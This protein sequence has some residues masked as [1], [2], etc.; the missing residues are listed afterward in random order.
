[1]DKTAWTVEDH[2]DGQPPASVGLYEHFIELVAA[3]GPFSYAVSKTT[4]TLK[5]TRRGF[6]GG[7]PTPRG[8]VGYLDLQR[9][10]EDPRIT[11]AERYTKRLFTHRFRVVTLQELNDEFSGWIREAYEVGR[12]AHLVDQR[13]SPTRAGFYLR[14]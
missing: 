13:R 6:A 9:V 12:G 4:I 11:S 1:M 5:G 7:R 3:C 14:A 2:L 8:M 10:V